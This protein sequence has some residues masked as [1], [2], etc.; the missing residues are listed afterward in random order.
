[1][2][3]GKIEQISSPAA[4]Y[5]RPKTP[6]VAR[7]IGR[8]T[9]IHGSLVEVRADRARLSTAFG[10]FVGTPNDRA[11]VGQA[12]KIVV[13]SESL[14]IFP[15]AGATRD[16]LALQYQGNVLPGVMERADVVG[17][18]VQMAITLSGGSTVVLEG[19]VDKYRRNDLVLSSDVWIAWRPQDATVIAA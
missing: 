8:N 6:F 11:A 16:A 1:M 15:A 12:V 5:T 4:L 10:Q 19:H 7:F 18:L 14:E 13:P 3:Q 2:N 9:L 17:H